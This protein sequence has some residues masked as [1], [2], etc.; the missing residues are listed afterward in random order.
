GVILHCHHFD[1]RTIVAFQT[2]CTGDER[3]SK[4]PGLHGRV[5]GEFLDAGRR[6]FGAGQKKPRRVGEAQGE[7]SVRGLAVRDESSWCA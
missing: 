5:M 6:L 2:P 1:R 3:D 7:N 4:R